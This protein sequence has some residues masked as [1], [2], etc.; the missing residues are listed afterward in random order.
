MHNVT[1]KGQ[2]ITLAHGFPKPGD[3][4]EEFELV[5]HELHDKTLSSFSNKKKLIATVPSLDTPVCSL[6][7]KKLQE[8]AKAHSE[9]HIIVISADLPFAQKRFCFE[10]HISN[11]TV[12]SSMRNHSFGKHYGV[13]IESGPLKG[14]LARSIII[15]DE[16]NHVVYSE[17]VSEIT[18]EPNYEK[19]FKIIKG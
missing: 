12:L 10:H 15:A 5:D 14:L 18:E 3:T 4:I 19:A 1:L 13:L 9:C 7:T 2:K 6:E 8:F 17:L 16:N 11:L